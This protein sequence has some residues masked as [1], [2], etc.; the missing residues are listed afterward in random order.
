MVHIEFTIT[1]RHLIIL[2]GLLLATVVL[3]PG[4]AWASH[5]FS[6]VPD[7]DWAHDDI[8]WLSDNGLTYGCEDGSVFCPDDPVTRRQLAVF[9]HR[10]SGDT[11]QTIDG[12]L[13]AIET[14]L[15]GVSRNGDVLLF[16]GMN[17]Q[18]VNRTG[19]TSGTPNGLG[20]LII[21]YNAANGD[22]QRTGSHFVVIGDFHSYTSY[23]GAVIGSGNTVSGAF[24]SVIG[25][26]G[27]T[28]SG[29]G[30]TVTG[31]ALNTASGGGSSVTGG[32]ENKAAGDS[33][34]VTGGT[35]S[36]ASGFASSVTGGWGSVA[37]GDRSAVTGGDANTASG[38][39]SSV[40]GGGSNEAS[41]Q[42]SSVTGGLY[43]TAVGYG[44]T[45]SG[46]FRNE[47]QGYSSVVSGGDTLV[48]VHDFGHLP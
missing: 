2:I 5:Q 28:A 13:G 4:V 23:S 48:A 31:G 9:L 17:L 8:A 27:N 25:G 40:T 11:G 42:Y 34:S 33:S 20:N 15:D 38:Q 24:A 6:D 29:A 21:G 22:E 35:H 26:A 19:S 41:G 12:R 1:R 3:V 43:S 14:L 47:A 37:S 46:G 18:I 39:V 10:L 44:S 16:D 7:S 45:V 30:S 36:T 32:G